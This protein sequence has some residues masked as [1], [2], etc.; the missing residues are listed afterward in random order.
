MTV[1]DGYYVISELL[2]KAITRFIL[3]RVS[4][5]LFKILTILLLH[6]RLQEDRHPS[7]SYHKPE[8]LR[9]WLKDKLLSKELIG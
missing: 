5:D 7:A 9:L 1:A 3:D 4:L 8:S 6:S 2:Q